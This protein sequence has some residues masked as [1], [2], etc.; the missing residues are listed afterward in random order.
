MRTNQSI[1]FWA[2]D[3]RPREKLQLKG[4]NVLSDSELLAIIIGSGSRKKSALEL[5]QEILQEHQ[6]D[7]QIL[8]RLGVADFM[9]FRGIG[10]AKAISIVAALELGK[11]QSQKPKKEI[12]KIK[13]S[14]SAFEQ[15]KAYL[16]FIPHEEFY[17][18]Y[19]KSNNEVIKICRISIGGIAGTLVDSR[20]IFKNGIDVLASGLILA[21]NH[22]S[23]KLVPSAQDKVLT[24][25]ITDFG[26]MI[27]IPVI[28][29]LII[30]DNGYFSFADSNLL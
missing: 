2:E 5:S 18:I 1:K 23:G 21:H 4:R 20:I 24:K 27:G 3:D 6:N 10:E 8:T 29:H 7:L 30:S 9:K 11:R 14:L 17:A 16:Q 28:D 13:S 26:E 19:L 22:P 25:K 15:L 12:I